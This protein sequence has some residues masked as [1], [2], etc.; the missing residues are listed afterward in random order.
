MTAG[1][2]WDVVADVDQVLRYHFMVNALRAGSV[3]A[4][5]A[6]A[7]GWFM[8][9]RRQAFAGHTLAV[10][11]FPGAAGATLLGID[12]GL[13]F[14]A[15]CVAGALAIA[16]LAGPRGRL[17][18]SF[19]EES[20]VVGTVQALGLASG[21]LFVS[22]YRGLLGGINA[23]LFGTITGVS[24]AQVRLLVVAGAVC[25]V[26]LAFLARPLL[27]AT[28]DPDVAAARG[29]PVR[30]VSTAFLVVLGVAAAGTSQVTGSLLVF[31]LLV[32]PG[33][34]AQQLTARPWPGLLLAVALGLTVVWIGAVVAFFSPYPIG[35]WVT[36]VAFGT[37]LAARGYR[38]LV[39]R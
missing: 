8:V 9:L 28:L 30:A 10:I 15:F 18:T 6:G 2:S 1:L 25:L 3:V 27:L 39:D 22:L 34:A 26:L 13:G 31:A 24:D 12:V 37:Y 21:F 33:A 35:F 16:L 20:A 7:V 4:V 23:L 38:A 11:G 29:V 14:F 19:R 17:G 32:A 36:T 5:V